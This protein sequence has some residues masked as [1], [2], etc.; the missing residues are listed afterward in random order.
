MSKGVSCTW[1]ALKVCAFKHFFI[2]V[3]LFKPCDYF[4]LGCF[5]T[6][7]LFLAVDCQCLSLIGMLPRIVVILFVRTPNH[8]ST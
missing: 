1:I 5:E 8:D 3:I 4:N 7:D 6:D 2:K